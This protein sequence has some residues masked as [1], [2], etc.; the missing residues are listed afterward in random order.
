MKRNEFIPKFVENIPENLE[1]GILYVSEIYS[2]SIHMCFCGCGK[3]VVVPFSPGHWKYTRKGKVVSLSPSI[4]SWQLPC[5]SHYI[6]MDNKVK[7]C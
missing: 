3:E 1:E 4:G 7:W 2:T 6:I 5:K